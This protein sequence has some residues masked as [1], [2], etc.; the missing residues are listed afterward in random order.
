MNKI[1][2]I[3]TFF[4]LFFLIFDSISS[5][6]SIFYQQFQVIQGVIIAIFTVEW[7]YRFFKSQ[8]KKAFFWNIHSIIELMSFLPYLLMGVFGSFIDLRLLWV[9]RIWKFFSI[10]RITRYFEI[11]NHLSKAFKQHFFKFEIAFLSIFAIWLVSGIVMYY[12]E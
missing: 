10:L 9:L 7:T 2:G 12:V 3:T 8:D 11:F 1:V 4:S 6:G 5:V